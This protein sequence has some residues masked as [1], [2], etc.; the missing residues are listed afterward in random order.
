MAKRTPAQNRAT[1]E[2]RKQRAINEGFSGYGS[3][4]GYKEKHVEKLPQEYSDEWI[5]YRELHPD[6]HDLRRDNPRRLVAYYENIIQPQ[7]DE[8][9][10]DMTLGY[11]RH[12]AVGYFRQWEDM[13]EQE[14]V[15]AMRS[16]YG[17]S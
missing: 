11:K 6:V 7:N 12:L 13:S 5:G 16:I 4:R 15:D 10:S 17:D 9:N 1:Y 3:M 2:R 14:A 8:D